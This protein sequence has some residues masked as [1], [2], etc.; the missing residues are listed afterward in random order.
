MLQRLLAP[1]LL[2]A[3]TAGVPAAAQDEPPLDT[4]MA[5]VGETEITLGHMLVLRGTLP[6]QYNQI[7][8]DV[9][10]RGV[11]DQLVQQELLSQSHEGALSRVAQ[12]R[13]DNEQRAIAASEVIGEITGEA[14]TDEALQA[15]YDSEYT[16][17]AEET[18]YRASH[19]LVETE[20][21]AQAL[22]E[23]IAGGANFAALAQE[24][25]TGPSGPSG[26]ELGWFGAGVM[27][28]EFSEAV[29]ALDVGEVSDP[30]KTQFGW[31]VIKLNETRAKEKPALADVR[32][33]LADTLRRQA[34]DA[35]VA[36]LEANSAVDRSGSDGMDPALINRFDLLEN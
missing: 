5:T 18:E 14:V 8:P 1:V 36:Q 17:A 15:A 33:E 9:L 23:E 16:G 3:L 35:H 12:L 34:L 29:T 20:E 22:V 19:I 32:D 30:V 7:P 27:V 24:H 11:L 25:S 21:E 6:E 31:H 13:L 4:V 10:F 28:P 26:G 2:A